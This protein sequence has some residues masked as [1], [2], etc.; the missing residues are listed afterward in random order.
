MFGSEKKTDLIKAYFPENTPIEHIQKLFSSY[1][2]N[3]TELGWPTSNPTFRVMP[4]ENWNR[5]W[6][7][8]YKPLR[9]TLRIV[10]KP[11]WSE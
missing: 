9:V 7:T 5:K 2:K 3:L 4:V 11:P 6:K 10:V 1:L 8:Y